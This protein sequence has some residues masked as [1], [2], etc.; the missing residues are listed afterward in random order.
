MVYVHVRILYVC[1]HCTGRPWLAKRE[2]NI[3]GNDRPAWHGMDHFDLDTFW[4]YLSNILV[5]LDRHHCTDNVG[6]AEQL[7]IRAEG[8][9]SVLRAVLGRVSEN[10]GGQL[11]ED[12]EV[13]L[14]VLGSH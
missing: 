4:Q 6:L 11:A 12:I 2:C 10:S 7:L 14:Y 1:M 3:A 8:C 5:Q 9:Q 13:L